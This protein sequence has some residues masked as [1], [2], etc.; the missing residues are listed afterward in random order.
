MD[1]LR[2]DPRKAYY[3]N[4][5]ALPKT[6][7]SEM[8]LRGALTYELTGDK[9]PL[10]AWTTERDHFLV[11]RNYI[12]LEAFEQLPFGV[13]DSRLR[14]FPRAKF[15]TSVVLDYKNPHLTIQRDGVSALLNAYNGVLNLRCGAGKT[16]CAIEAVCRVGTPALVLVN[17][18]GLAH[19]WIESIL[20]FTDLKK[21][22]IGFIGDGE[23]KW[24][25]AITLATVQT[26]AGMVRK[27]KLPREMVEH[28]GI[29]L[30][31]EAHNT[32]GPA[33]FGLAVTPFHGRRWGLTATPRRGD[34]FD[35]L[36]QYT[37]GGVIYSYL[38]PEL[39]PLIYF[40]R[41]PTKLN[42]KDKDCFTACTDVSGEL[43]LQRVYGYLATREDRT[44]LI[45]EEIK[46]ALKQ[47]RQ[48]LVLSQSR[49]MLERLEREFP[50]A[51][52][53]HGGVDSREER[54]RRIRECN[55][56]IATSTLGK[57]A[58]DKPKLDTLLVLEPYTKPGVLQQLLGRI[59]R[60]FP[61]KQRA[62]AVFYDDVHIKDMH[63]MCMK[64]RSLF[65][66]WPDN[67]GGR[68]RWQVTGTE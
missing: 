7:V 28:F 38:E 31:D 55:P 47:G 9:E 4:V 40:R 5:L 33:F 29:T 59:Q 64:M 61:G 8:Q 26:V 36:L 11:P 1:L 12:P 52:V 42:L 60:P 65:S 48:I 37:L 6:H 54:F 20:E 15:K 23:M 53:V 57:E 21:E 10:R 45:V 43:H 67:Q 51:G 25:K 13:V 66:R 44:K 27:G 62:M 35:S 18:K 58:L 30:A 16:V 34:S 2:R 41:L 19:Q 68:L 50:M 17:N 56:V 46:A 3:N 32:A 49:P 14:R 24:Q 39:T 22:D 63:K